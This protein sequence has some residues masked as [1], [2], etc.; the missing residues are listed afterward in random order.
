VKLFAEAD[1]ARIEAKLL[2][3]VVG[4]VRHR[5]RHD[6]S[7]DVGLF[8]AG[9]GPLWHGSDQSVAGDDVCSSGSSGRA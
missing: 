9:L 5:R 1:I 6:A 2:G 4:V 7:P 3:K 8:D